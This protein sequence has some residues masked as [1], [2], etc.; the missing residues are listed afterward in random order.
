MLIAT[1]VLRNDFEESKVT[2]LAQAWKLT[3]SKAKSLG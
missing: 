2:L 3:Q 1:D